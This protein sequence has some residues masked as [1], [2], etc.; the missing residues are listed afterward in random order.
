MGLPLRTNIDRAKLLEL[1]GRYR[2]A[3]INLETARRLGY[4]RC[5]ER[6]FGLSLLHVTVGQILEHVDDHA[7]CRVIEDVLV[8]ALR[9]I[10]DV[11]IPP[12]W[13]RRPDVV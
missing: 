8:T 7:C 1:A 5:W 6:F 4:V 13:V 3:T 10:P 12:E 2:D 11:D 9:R